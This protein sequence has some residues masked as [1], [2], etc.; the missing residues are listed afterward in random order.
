MKRGS[1]PNRSA[2]NCQRVR[3]CPGRGG[4]ERAVAGGRGS[5][6]LGISG[7]AEHALRPARVSF[8]PVGRGVQALRY[9]E[10]VAVRQQEKEAAK[11]SVGLI[12]VLVVVLLAMVGM[13]VL[14]FTR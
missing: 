12:L 3:G 13:A 4:A 2:C 10:V 14:A 1:T 9:E 7:Y 5:C 6:A 8:W 11:V